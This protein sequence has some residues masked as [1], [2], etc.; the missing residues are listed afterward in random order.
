MTN[1]ENDLPAKEPNGDIDHHQFPDLSEVKGHEISDRELTM[2]GSDF[3]GLGREMA[4]EGIHVWYQS[5][6][7]ARERTWHITDHAPRIQMNFNLQ[8]NTTY[9]SNKLGKVFVRFSPGQHNLMLIPEG[10]IQVQC[11]PDEHSEIF[12]L[13]LAADFFFSLLPPSHLLSVHFEKGIRYKLPAFMSMRN[14]PVTGPMEHIIFEIIQ[15]PYAGFHKSLFVRAKAIE[16]LLLQ[17]EQNEHLPLPSFLSTLS[18]EHAEQMHLVKKL[19]DENLDQQWSLKDLARQVGS[20]E[21]N[22]KKYFKEVF[23]ETVFGYLHQKRMETAKDALCQPGSSVHDVAQRMG[24][25]HPTHFTAAFK[26]HY[27]ILPSKLSKP[28]YSL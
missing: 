20:N 17:M 9:Y 8:G 6:A 14:L 7:V 21:F 24:Y 5:L 27:G 12:S 28:N 16:L 4:V 10:D 25:K 26:K 1:K 2:E 19:L 3:F 15:C 23:G 13:N 18:S 11:A 22:L